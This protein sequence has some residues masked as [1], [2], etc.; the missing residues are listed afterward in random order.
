MSLLAD[1]AQL[2]WGA[3][4]F[5]APIPVALRAATLAQEA[6]RLSARVDI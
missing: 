1:L 3:L 5:L 6:V 2:N 4:V